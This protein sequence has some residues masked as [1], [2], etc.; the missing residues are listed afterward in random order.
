MPPLFN[1]HSVFAGIAG[2]KINAVFVLR[3]Q[4][5]GRF[6][7]LLKT[8]A[9][10]PLIFTVGGQYGAAA[11]KNAGAFAPVAYPDFVVAC[12]QAFGV[13]LFPDFWVASF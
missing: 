13:I 9:V 8:T 4:A 2:A 11:I 5:K 7:A 6:A 12:D 1:G 3:I 10:L